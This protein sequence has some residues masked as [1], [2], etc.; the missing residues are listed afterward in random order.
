MIGFYMADLENSRCWTWSCMMT[1]WKHFPHY[2]QFVPTGLRWIPCTKA[3]DAE[4][5]WF[6]ETQLIKIYIFMF[7][8]RKATKH[9]TLGVVVSCSQRPSYNYLPQNIWCNFLWKIKIFTLH[10]F[11][12]DLSFQ[13]YQKK[14]THYCKLWVHRYLNFV[15]S[16]I[17]F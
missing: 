4:L 1:S 10:Y 12:Q 16:I 14:V 2:W 5:S 6:I 3:S 15:T 9:L 11:H 8:Q 13:I 17:T 7:P